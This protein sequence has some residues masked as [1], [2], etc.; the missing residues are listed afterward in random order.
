MSG[1]CFDV[2]GD[3]R[4]RRG[5]KSGDGQDDAWGLQ[6]TGNLSQTAFPQSCEEDRKGIFSLR[7]LLGLAASD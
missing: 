2:G 6:H 7:T 1:D 4:A 3:T 5:V